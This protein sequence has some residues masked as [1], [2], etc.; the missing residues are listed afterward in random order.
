MFFAQQTKRRWTH[1][2]RKQSTIRINRCECYAD[3]CDESLHLS[4]KKNVA[5]P[6]QLVSCSAFSGQNPE[7]AA[8]YW[9][10]D[11]IAVAMWYTIFC[12]F[13]N[14]VTTCIS[15]SITS[16]HVILVQLNSRANNNVAG[17]ASTAPG[18]RRSIKSAS[19]LHLR[20]AYSGVDLEDFHSLS[21]QMTHPPPP[22]TK[23]IQR[24]QQLRVPAY[25]VPHAMAQVCVSAQSFNNF[26]IVDWQFGA[27]CQVSPV[28]TYEWWKCNVAGASTN[29]KFASTSVQLYEGMLGLLPCIP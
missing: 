8:R 21:Y 10:G 24:K 9:P 2:F 26:I 7:C 28:V 27:R 17:R 14:S 29:G 16:I 15:P 5:T 25:T 22:P 23:S 3:F 18:R 1:V 4:R 11:K 13:N 19:N 6:Y 12:N 20:D